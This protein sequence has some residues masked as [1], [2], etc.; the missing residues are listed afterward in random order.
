MTTTSKRLEA[1]EKQIADAEQRTAVRIQAAED[2]ATRAEQ[3]AA[4]VEQK[5]VTA[6]QRAVRAEWEVA[7]LKP[8]LIYAAQDGE[9]PPK[10]ENIFGAGS[11]GLKP[12]PDRKGYYYVVIYHPEV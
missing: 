10:P 5:V 2:R 6:E 3:R 4:A 12:D 9:L 7:R 11:W 1:A 8:R